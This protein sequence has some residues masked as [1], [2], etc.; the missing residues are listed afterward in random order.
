VTADLV[1]APYLVLLDVRGRWVRPGVPVDECGK[2]R[3][4]VRAAIQRLRL[5]RTSARAIGQVESAEAAAAGCDQHWSDMIWAIASLGTTSEPAAPAALYTGPAPARICVYRV[6]TDQQRTAKPAGDFV[7][8]RQLT[9]GQWAASSGRSRP[10]SRRPHA[11]P[12]RPGSP[13][14]ARTPARPTWSWTAAG[15]SWLRRP[16]VTTHRGRDRPPWSPYSPG[17]STPS[18]GCAGRVAPRLR[19]GHAHDEPVCDSTTPVSLGA[20]NTTAAVC[21]G[22]ARVG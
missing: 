1:L 21:P 8:R 4:E 7:S 14:C 6:P 20:L 13:W 15:G 2:P 12:R 5:T 18:A 3:T 9:G 16:P 10:P 17:H 11:P 19:R 22:T